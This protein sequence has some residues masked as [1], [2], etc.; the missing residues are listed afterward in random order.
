MPF[1][2]AE[3]KPRLREYLLTQLI[4]RPDYPLKDDEP[5]ISMGLID[6]FSLAQVAVFV[7]DTFGVYLPDTDL[8]VDNMDTLNQMVAEIVRES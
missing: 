7:E 6:S 4:R 2:P 1:D 5:M 8:T 3:I